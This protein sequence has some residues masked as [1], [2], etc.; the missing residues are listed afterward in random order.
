MSASIFTNHG[1]EWGWER[2]C[3][4]FP[5]T[6]LVAP[7]IGQKRRWNQSC[8]QPFPTVKAVCI[9]P[10]EAPYLTFPSSPSALKTH[11]L[12]CCSHMYVYMFVCV[13]MHIYTLDVSTDS[14]YTYQLS[15]VCIY[16]EQYRTGMELWALDYR[17]YSDFSGYIWEIVSLGHRL[18]SKRIQ[19]SSE[20]YIWAVKFTYSLKG[21]CLL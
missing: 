8:Q 4:V 2:F 17:Q 1:R 12:K 11:L 3:G 7:L 6:I 18:N 14:S 9:P 20:L 15:F 21:L 5:T 13:Y 10:R 16:V 19:I